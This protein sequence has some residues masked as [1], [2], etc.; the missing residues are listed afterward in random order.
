[1][2]RADTY[3]V[4]ASR[5][6]RACGAELPGAVRWCGQCHAPVR[7]LTP[8]EPVWRE[9]EF[10]DQP[11]HT[12]DAV[13]HWS[14]WE[15]S[16][17]TFGPVGRIAI[18]AIGALWVCGAAVQSPITLVFVLPLVVLLIRSVWQRGWVI[19]AHLLPEHH[20]RSAE[21][22]PPVPWDRSEVWRGVA[23]AVGGLVGGAILLY[24][25]DP[26]PRFIVIVT[27]IVATAAW[28]LRKIDGR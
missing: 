12:G 27:A 4:T 19:P 20:A 22:A 15:K 18:T 10:V 1:M 16:A 11:I 26:I 6:C 24:E 21:P 28:A 5:T 23:L 9:G 7:E 17:T 8:R 13:P 2:R 25:N 3:A 14:R